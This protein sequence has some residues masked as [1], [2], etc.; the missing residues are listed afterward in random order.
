MPLELV[1]LIQR[2]TKPAGETPVTA[3]KDV[4]TG[5]AVIV[6]GVVRGSVVIEKSILPIVMCTW[7]V[8]KGS[9]SLS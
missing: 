3:V 9:T 5:E 1:F 4:S 8:S 2:G 7:K 6:V